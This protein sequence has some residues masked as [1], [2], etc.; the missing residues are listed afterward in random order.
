MRTFRCEEMVCEGCADRIRRAFEV[1]DI[2]GQVNLGAGTVAVQGDDLQAE[3][4]VKILDE[5][6]FSAVEIQEKSGK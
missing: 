1:S 5:L 2:R 4:A 3:R 6:G